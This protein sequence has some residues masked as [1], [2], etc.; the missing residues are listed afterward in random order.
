MVSAGVSGMVG[1]TD[2]F[3]A[4]A[5]VSE[6]IANTSPSTALAVAGAGNDVGAKGS[7]A[8]NSA[9]SSANPLLLPPLLLLMAVVVAKAS[10]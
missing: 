9:F 8:P 3:G 10:P 7:F 6:A 4:A 5:A 2:S 1:V